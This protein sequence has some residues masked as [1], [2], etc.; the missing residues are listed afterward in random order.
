MNQKGQYQRRILYLNKQIVVHSYTNLSSEVFS[1]AIVQNTEETIETD[2]LDLL[3]LFDATGSVIDKKTL[4][5][6]IKNAPRV[7]KYI[8][9]MA[10]VGVEK[11]QLPFV[12][13]VSRIA[14]LPVKVCSSFDEAKDW[15]A[16]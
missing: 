1:A 7:R 12:E 8:Q 13:Y 3:V 11:M 14:G 6:C 5:T 9:K 4:M 10:I 2:D 15:L 16:E